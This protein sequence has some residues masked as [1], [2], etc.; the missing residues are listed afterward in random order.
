MIS[1]FFIVMGVI[2]F[3]FLQF[4]LTIYLKNYKF[5][6]KNIFQPDILYEIS[7]KGIGKSKEEM[8][9]I[10]LQELIKKYP[11]HIWKE[12]KWLWFNAGGWMGHLC[13][14]HASLT[15]YLIFFG[16]PTPT[17][18]HSGRYPIEVFDFVIEG[19]LQSIV[20]DFFF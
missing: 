17:S 3:I 11:Q 6:D 5:N 1:I 2:F 15:E 8:F 13:F 4:I 9:E 12:K 19:N 18:G 7:K 16:S 20:K 10:I 14:L